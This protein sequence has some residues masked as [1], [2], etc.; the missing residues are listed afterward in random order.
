MA[1]V[2]SRCILLRTSDST[3]ECFSASAVATLA[4]VCVAWGDSGESESVDAGSHGDASSV[5]CLNVAKRSLS[6]LCNCASANEKVTDTFS[7]V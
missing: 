4:S 5:V 6:I 1:L 7:M 2:L 3:A